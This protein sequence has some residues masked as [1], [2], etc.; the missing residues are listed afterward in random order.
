PRVDDPLDLTREERAARKLPAGRHRDDRSGMAIPR[1]GALHLRSENRLT[2][3]CA[4][5][6]RSVP[7][8]KEHWE[9]AADAQLRS[10]GAVARSEMEGS[11]SNC[12]PGAALFGIGATILGQ[13]LGR[14]SAR[15]RQGATS[16]PDQQS[17]AG[18]SRVHVFSETVMRKRTTTKSRKKV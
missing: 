13:G 10:T 1:A 5:S 14:G 8:A 4:F 17:S 12:R 11:S 7:A 16:A 15:T 18:A 9:K 2:P 6:R 3:G